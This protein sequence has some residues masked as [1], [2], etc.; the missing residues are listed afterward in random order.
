MP[1]ADRFHWTWLAAVTVVALLLSIRR[2]RQRLERAAHRLRWWAAGVLYAAGLHV[3]P[4][5][6][7]PP[8]D[9]PERIAAR[10]EARERVRRRNG[11]HDGA[12]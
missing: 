11:A 4:D 5:D 9:L 2:G 6:D 12:T 3:Q 1:D 7:S 10:I 8:N